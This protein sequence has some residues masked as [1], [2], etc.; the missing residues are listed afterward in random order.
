M[1]EAN[2]E[3]A[4]NILGWIIKS[5]A[6]I[7]VAKWAGT[8]FLEWLRSYNER[9]KAVEVSVAAVGNNIDKRLIKIETTLE[10]IKGHNPIDEKK[11][12]NIFED[13][14]VRVIRNARKK[15]E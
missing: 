4:A 2:Q 1:N 3:L 15:F 14:I 13:N 5:G 10:L 11:V 8:K 6:G 9:L 12:V 7:Y